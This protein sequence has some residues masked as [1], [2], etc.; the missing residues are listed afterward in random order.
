MKQGGGVGVGGAGGA[1]SSFLTTTWTPSQEG[2]E[3]PQEALPV[4][5][6]AG[7]S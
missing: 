7:P 6:T 5:Q 1:L 2:Q 3:C 4:R